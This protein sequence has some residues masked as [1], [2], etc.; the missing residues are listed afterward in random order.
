[1][2]AELL[3]RNVNGLMRNACP[4]IV[5]S[6]PRSI[7][8]ITSRVIL[9]QSTTC[10]VILAPSGQYHTARVIQ[11]YAMNNRSYDGSKSNPASQ[12]RR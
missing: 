6:A 9:E 11:S 5:V 8:S 12:C 4:D 3:T 2:S 7:F 10:L 1:M